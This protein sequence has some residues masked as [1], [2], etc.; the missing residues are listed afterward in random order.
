[1]ILYPLQIQKHYRQ[2]CWQMNISIHLYQYSYMMHTFNVTLYN[3]ISSIPSLRLQEPKC[4]VK[5]SNHASKCFH[6]MF[7]ESVSMSNSPI[8]F[9]II[10]CM[11]TND[12]NDL[13][14][15][16]N[17]VTTSLLLNTDIYISR[18]GNSITVT[19]QCTTLLLH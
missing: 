1:M 9:C 14:M 12:H 3:Y 17:L 10:Q 5:D 15:E 13:N 16:N 19:Y 4:M 8:K 7:E 6:K 2:K 11:V 18:T